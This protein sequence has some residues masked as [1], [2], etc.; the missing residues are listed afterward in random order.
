[1]KTV[2][3][4]LDKN[5]NVLYVAQVRNVDEKK[6]QELVL[7]QIDREEKIKDKELELLK[8]VDELEKKSTSLEHDI[9]VLKGEE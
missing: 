5:G 8:R 7:Q 9:K 3:V 6:Y 4:I 2:S 1:M